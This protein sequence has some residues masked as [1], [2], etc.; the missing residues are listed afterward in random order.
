MVCHLESISVIHR[1][2]RKI[3]D[4]KAEDYLRSYMKNSVFIRQKK[5][6]GDSRGVH[7]C[8]NYSPKFCHLG[9]LLRNIFRSRYYMRSTDLCFTPNDYICISQLHYRNLGRYWKLS[10]RYHPFSFEN[11]L[12]IEFYKTNSER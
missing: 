12:L 8:L 1:S 10:H 2:T 5:Y 6:R 4:T 11:S 9:I 3:T 7:R